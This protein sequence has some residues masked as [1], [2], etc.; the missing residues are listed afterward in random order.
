MNVVITGAAGNLGAGAL[1]RIV[2][3]L[4]GITHVRNP[5][6]A[7]GGQE[8]ESLEQVRQYAPQAFRIQER[9]VTEADYAAVTERYPETQQAAATLRWTGS[10]HTVFI[11]VDRK[12]NRPIDAPFE[13]TLRAFVERFRLAGQDLEIDAPRF[14]SLDI[15]FTVCVK[16]GYL[17]SQVKQELLRLFSTRD[18]PDGR[19]GFFHPDNFTFGQPLYLAQIYQAAMTRYDPSWR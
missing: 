6:P 15:V 7:T 2:I 19:R 17:R 8:V 14:V 3:N 13:T 4:S 9:A 10:W 1:T 18:L 5:L 16:P 11:T 12:R